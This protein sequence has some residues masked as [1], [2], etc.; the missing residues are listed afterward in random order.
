MP[1]ITPRWETEQLAC[2]TSSRY[3][4]PAANS[5][6]RNA[7]AKL[8]LSSLCTCGVKTQAPSMPS[9]FTP[10]PYQG[11]PDEPAELDRFWDR[12][13][14]VMPGS[15]QCCARAFSRPENPS[16][17]LPKRGPGRR[18]ELDVLGDDDDLLGLLSPVALRDL[19]LD[20]LAF[21]K[22]AVSVRL[23][24]GEVDE[25][26]LATVDGDKAVALVRVEP[27]DGALS[28]SK[29]LPNCCSGFEP[30]PCNRGTRRSRLGETCQRTLSRSQLALPTATRNDLTV[31]ARFMTPDT[32]Q[33]RQR[34]PQ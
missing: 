12:V 23:D 16:A 26:V 13:S 7:S 2:A 1:L 20:P 22:A 4:R 28:H 30:R 17:R 34:A 10:R 3:P 18:S 25:N 11:T 9:G 24:R 6:P 21:F 5:A 29:Q 15:R 32:R 27:L 8:P 19:E 14:Q 33:S 31:C